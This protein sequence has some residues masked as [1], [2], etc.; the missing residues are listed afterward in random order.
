MSKDIVR[1]KKEQFIEESNLSCDEQGA[2]NRTL[3][4]AKNL[5]G[6]NCVLIFQ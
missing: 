1:W 2:C 3:V 5:S 4:G 6:N